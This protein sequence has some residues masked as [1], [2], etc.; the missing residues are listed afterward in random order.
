MYPSSNANAT[1]E[2]NTAASS[3]QADEAA[4]MM[5]PQDGQNPIYPS[6]GLPTTL[7][8]NPGEGG[9]VNGG[10][11]YYPEVVIPVRPQPS[12]PCYSCSSIGTA[13]SKVRF[14]NAAYG[15]QPFRVFI[16][17]QYV[18]NGLG[19]TSLTPYGR[20][21]N[22][23]QSVTVTGQNGYIYIQKPMPIRANESSTIAIINT[24]GGLDLMQISDTP[25]EKP[26]L[27]SC[28]RCCN[29]ALNTAPLD[30][31]LNDGRVIFSDVRYKE[32][33]S[34]VRARRGTYGFYIANTDMQPTPYIRDIEV[35]TS[36]ERIVIPQA[37]VSSYVEVR[38]NAMYTI[39]IFTRDNSLNAIQT[40]VVEDR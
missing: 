22:G 8:P 40:L 19:Y 25:C 34:F 2:N 28:L 37:L 7:L 35:P 13:T 24:S 4:D 27:M 1:N 39:Y 6:T 30:V 29:L 32:V 36:S 15:Y 9:P 14:L 20:V 5:L 16:N 18:V 10:V 38:A 12:Y 33:T 23:Y 11:P 26:L 17:R 3:R 31:I 21:A